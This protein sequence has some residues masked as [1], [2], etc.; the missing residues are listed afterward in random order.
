MATLIF[1]CLA[2]CKL[3]NLNA[4]LN[5]FFKR[6]HNKSNDWSFAPYQPLSLIS[7][8]CALNGKLRTLAN[9]ADSEDADQTRFW[10]C[11]ATC[12]VCAS[13]LWLCFNGSRLVCLPSI[14]CARY[15]AYTLQLLSVHMG[16]IHEF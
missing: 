14:N 16:Y 6:L 15:P 9:H 3:H 13:R 11:Y 4:S 12:K 10:I 8:C 2:M 5:K 1:S 7:V